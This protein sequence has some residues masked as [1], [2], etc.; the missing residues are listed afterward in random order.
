M[1]EMF[2]KVSVDDLY[3]AS[4]VT[5]SYGTNSGIN[6]EGIINNVC[7]DFGYLTVV[8]KK[9]REYIDLNNP[10]V[11][12]IGK[13]QKQSAANY[14]IVY[15]EP[16]SKYYIICQNQNR[17]ISKRKAIII[18]HNYYQEFNNNYYEYKEQQKIKKV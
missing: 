10:E 5:S 13:E 8:L 16:F 2:E 14:I 11:K 3:F 15:K 4:I 17:M 1:F 18:A 9:D 6:S 12:V 7:G